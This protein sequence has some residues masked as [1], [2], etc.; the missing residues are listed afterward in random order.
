MKIVVTILALGLILSYNALA[1]PRGI[2]PPIKLAE[3]KVRNSHVVSVEQST[4]V[5]TPKSPVF[6]LAKFLHFS[7][8]FLDYQ[9]T[10]HA[11]RSPMFQEQDIITR[12]Y[13]RTPPAFCA[14]KSVE[15]IAQN[16]LFDTIYRWS[17]PIAYITVALF[18]LMRIVAFRENM[19]VMGVR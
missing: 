15:M 3:V 6:N 11:S 17:R 13:W 14:F 7:V 4:K 8:S 10:F 18:A 9:T 2:E 16:W 5:G 19:K 1:I 12:L